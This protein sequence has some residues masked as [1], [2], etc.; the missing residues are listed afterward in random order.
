MRM[1]KT[2]V[3]NLLNPFCNLYELAD[4]I[5]KIKADNFSA[6]MCRQDGVMVVVDDKPEEE[7]LS[8]KL[9]SIL[10]EAAGKEQMQR[11]V[12]LSGKQLPETFFGRNSRLVML[13][14]SNN[15]NQVSAFSSHFTFILISYT[16][17]R[18]RD[19]AD[20]LVITNHVCLSILTVNTDRF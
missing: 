2:I 16:I 12:D 8:E 10:Q 5:F 20:T 7:M 15:Q 1:V 17:P 14:L 18:M 13:K 19:H 6:E 3:K 4:S 11:V 9:V